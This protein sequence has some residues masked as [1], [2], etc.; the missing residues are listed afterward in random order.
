M[1]DK[2]SIRAEY[3]NGKWGL[4]TYYGDQITEFKYTYIEE[5]N[6]EYFKAEIGAKKNILRPDGTEVLAEWVPNVGRIYDGYFTIGRTIRK[7]AT[8]PT[9]YLD[10]LA[11]VNGT[12]IFPIAFEKVYWG[13]EEHKFLTAELE[14]KTVILG[15][16]GGMYDL[17]KAHLPKKLTIDFEDYIE[18]FVNWTL[19]GLQFFYRDTN[20]EIDVDRSY[21]IGEV[22]KAGMFMD[23]SVKLLKPAHKTRFILASAHAAVPCAV[24]EICENDPNVKKWGLATFHPNSYFKVLDIYRLDGVTQILLLHIPESAARL[25]A[26]NKILFNFIN[27]NPVNPMNLVE[28]AHES[29]NTKMRDEVHPR[30]LEHQFVERMHRPV[31]LDEDGHHLPMEPFVFPEDDELFHLSSVIWNM[32]EMGDIEIEYVE[33]DGFVWNGP[34]GTICSGCFYAKDINSRG[35]GCGCLAKE[36]MR[37]SVATGKCDHR[38]EFEEQLSKY[39]ETK[40]RKEQEA[41]SKAEKISNVHAIQ[42]ARQF[43]D[44]YLDGNI[45]NLRGFNLT[46]AIDPDCRSI[47]FFPVRNDL[48][49]SLMVLA[50]SDVWPSLNINAI[51]NGTYEVSCINDPEY[52]LG[53]N[54]MDQ[55]FMLM[56][57]LGERK[58]QH[59]KALSAFSSCLTI[60]NFIV[61]PGKPSFKQVLESYDVRKYM[62]NFLILMNE[63]MSDNKKACWDMCAAISKNKMA[64]EPYTGKGG[65]IRFVHNNLLEDYVDK[66]GNPTHI[67][68]FMW[69]TKKGATR[70]E[71]L[72]AVDTNCSLWE[73]FNTNRSNIIIEKL[74]RVLN[75]K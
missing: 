25:F 13:N 20:A 59:E 47:R 71:I 42:V 39:E 44:E 23:A 6:E 50:F 36:Q 34:K 65:F 19:P 45:E 64:M 49:N 75:L 62:D 27:D 57:K 10:G 31:G 2:V 26:K 1:T 38:K 28:M 30:S 12:I 37:N 56:N 7:T 22:I 41:K 46:R 69:G 5:W 72:D 9:R 43:I 4:V 3:R 70:D 55:Y 54:I 66:D 29:L 61:M 18:K 63:V 14:G 32:A 73:K 33:D 21:K 52:L 15:L 60:G 48:L 74:K 53:S 67:L 8:T 35:E 40:L 24:E 58:G 11:H 16:D 17:Q 51:E 68:S